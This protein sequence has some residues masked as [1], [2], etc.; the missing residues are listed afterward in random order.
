MKL[1]LALPAILLT[2]TVLAALTPEP[3][4]IRF[5]VAEGLLLSKTFT[6]TLE[7][8]SGEL[9]STMNG[10]EIPPQYLPDVSVHIEM[11]A[12]LV[13]R[14]EYLAASEGR[15]THLRR[16]YQTVAGNG[17][18]ESE[19][20]PAPTESGSFEAEC[21]LEG[22]TVE[23]RWDE[24]REEYRREQLDAAKPSELLE[25]L[26]PELDLLA[27]LPAGEVEV[28][29]RWEVELGAVTALLHPGGE[30]G[31]TEDPEEEESPFEDVSLEGQLKARLAEILE[32]DGKRLAVI[33]LEGEYVH[34]Q[35]RPTDLE[36][37]PVVDGTA[38]EVRT[39]RLAVE[40]EL[41][42]DLD[43]NHAVSLELTAAVDSTSETIRDADQPGPSFT[44]T[45]PFVGERKIAVE[46]E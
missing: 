15:P 18:W 22:E 29:D 39:S 28:G 12:R 23:F 37:V 35:Q 24:K 5:E 11:S 32:K 33:A 31:L 10:Q 30:L 34:E 16:E 45:L 4:A 38:H 6:S 2:T 14:D 17:S 43:A 26:D 44:S 46:F 40:G 25:K 21:D 3:T 7:L 9:S 41:L 42:W 36:H 20:P 19:V 13:V 8:D 27:F 1:S